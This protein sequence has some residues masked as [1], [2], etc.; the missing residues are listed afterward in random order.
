MTFQERW[1]INGIIAVAAQWIRLWRLL[2]AS[3][4]SNAT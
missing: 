3:Q 1:H 2:A 4:S